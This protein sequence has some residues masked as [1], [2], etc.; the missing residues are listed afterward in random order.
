MSHEIRTPMNGVVTVSDILQQTALDGEQTQLV[1]VLG[2]SARGLM[3][4]IDDILDI[5][6]IE[7]GMLSI[8]P[9]PLAPVELI[10]QVLD[11]FQTSV[12]EKGLRLSLLM[13]CCQIK[14]L[15]TRVASAN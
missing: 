5:S 14:S 12:E 13:R 3:A 4:I 6:K 7:A 11:L 15:A 8:R 2:Q 10:E 1:R 9:E